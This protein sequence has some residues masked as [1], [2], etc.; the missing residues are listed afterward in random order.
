[1]FAPT[2]ASFDKLPKRTVEDLLKPEFEAALSGILTYHAV[3]G[4]LD[5][6][7]VMAAIKAGK[8]KTVPTKV[9]GAELAVFMDGKNVILTDSKGGKST[10]TSTDLKASNG[11][12]HVIDT[13]L[14][15]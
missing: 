8:G 2:N 12:V 4:N 14:M 9:N 6:T 5:A 3:A 11:V 13:V 10:A 7:A 15:P 1:L